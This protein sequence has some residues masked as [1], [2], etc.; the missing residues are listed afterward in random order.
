MIN[1]DLE[2]V[3]RFGLVFIILIGLMW[4]NKDA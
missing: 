2:F 4:F 1:V 3:V